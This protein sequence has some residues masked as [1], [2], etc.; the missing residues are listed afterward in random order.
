M[1][2]L[3]YLLLTPYGQG[4]IEDCGGLEELIKSSE[5][6]GFFSKEKVDAVYKSWNETCRNVH[7]EKIDMHI[8]KPQNKRKIHVNKYKKG[9]KN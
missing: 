1:S 4:I 6:N 8:N 9:H 5:S 7:N 2:L 3:S